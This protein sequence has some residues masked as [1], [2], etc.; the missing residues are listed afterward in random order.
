MKKESIM[1]LHI[2]KSGKVQIVTPPKKLT[3]DERKTLEEMKV[4]EKLINL[5]LQTEFN[6]VYG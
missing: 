1:A 3:Q 6:V 4:N 5:A 2:D